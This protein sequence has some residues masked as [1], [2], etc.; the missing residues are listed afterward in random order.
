MTSNAVSAKGIKA[1]MPYPIL[2]C[3]FGEPTHKQVKMVICKLSANIMAISYPWVYSKGH[4]SL[5]QDPAIY[6]ARNGEAFN[7][8][9]IEPPAYPV[10]SVG[11]MT[12]KCK[13]LCATNT[14][15]H[16][17]WNT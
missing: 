14:A 1:Q 11:T 16:K 10:I 15:D 13:D 8:P 4:L 6:L 5:L 3:I 12:A 7:I 17:A 9:H 2:E